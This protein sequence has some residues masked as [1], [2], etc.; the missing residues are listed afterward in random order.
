M[1]E[2]RHGRHHIGILG[3]TFDSTG[4]NSIG[5]CAYAPPSLGFVPY[6]FTFAGNIVHANP[7]PIANG[8][9]VW[10]PQAGSGLIA[11]NVITGG[12]I[13]APPPVILDNNVLA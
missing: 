10:A 3:N 12:T 8:I 1:D 9:A 11:H 2:H 7:P 13:W 5:L 6:A 4:G